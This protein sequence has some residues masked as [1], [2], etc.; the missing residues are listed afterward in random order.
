MVLLYSGTV[1]KDISDSLKGVKQIPIDISEREIPAWLKAKARA[2][3]VELTDQALNYLI[4][5]IGP[6]P[7]LLSSEIGKCALLGKSVIDKDDLVEI[8]EGKRTYGVFTLIDAIKSGDTEK[9][10]NIYRVLR[11]TEEPYSLLGALNWQY[12]RSLGSAKTPGENNYA[13]SVF[14]VLNEADEEIKSSGGVF[15][16]ELLLVKL[17]RLSKR[18]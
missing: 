5:M 15:P 1:K 10:F 2:G 8:I 16:V 4:G 11:E 13:Y 18:R 17:L 12:S 3:G 6:D 14:K 7:G 9:V